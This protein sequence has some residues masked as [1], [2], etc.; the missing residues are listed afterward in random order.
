MQLDELITNMPKISVE[1]GWFGF[2]GPKTP[3]NDVFPPTEH[4]EITF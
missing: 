4:F 1:S 2:Y 3:K